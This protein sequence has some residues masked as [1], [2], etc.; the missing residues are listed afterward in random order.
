V[1][2]FGTGS[3]ERLIVAGMHGGSEY[4][5]IQLADSLIAYAK[6]HPEAI[7][8]DVTLFI[9]RNLNP[10]GEA[11]QHGAYGRAN[12]N[13]VDLNRNWDANWQADWSRDGC[14]NLLKTTGGT[15]PGSEPET[16]ALMA[17]IA[18]H[19]FDGIINYHS[20]ALG[21]FAGGVPDYPD[22]D[23]LAEAVK[24]VAPYPYPPIDTGC[25]Y[26]GGFVDWA[27]KQGIPA[28]DVELA[29]HTNTDLAIN[30]RIFKVFVTWKR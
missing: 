2:R 17:F 6:S 11:R 19:H 16:Q 12:A 27:A 9:L 15:G 8:T 26:T 21:I 25:I 14:W 18:Q 7:P 13:N 22:S 20:A 30:L 5:T 3:T 29:D 4:N 28:L 1:F 23:R 24:K 10:D